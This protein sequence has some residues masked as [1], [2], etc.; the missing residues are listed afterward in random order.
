MDGHY[1]AFSLQEQK[2][3]ETDLVQ[4]EMDT[5]GICLRK[6]PARLMPFAV[7]QEVAWQFTE[8]PF[9]PVTKPFWQTKMN[10]KC[11]DTEKAL[12]KEAAEKAL[13]KASSWCP[14]YQSAGICMLCSFA[15]WLDYLTCVML[16]VFP[17]MRAPTIA[18]DTQ[19]RSTA[20]SLREVRGILLAV[21]H[22]NFLVGSCMDRARSVSGNS[23]DLCR[24]TRDLAGS[25][26]WTD[27]DICHISLP[28]HHGSGNTVI[29]ISPFTSK[30]LK[31]LHLSAFVTVP[32]N[33]P[34]SSGIFCWIPSTTSYASSKS[35]SREKGKGKQQNIRTTVTRRS[36]RWVLV[37]FCFGQ[38]EWAPH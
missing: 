13:K 36:T 38:P 4:L 31:D 5:D 2:H 10:N 3:G 14:Y 1:Q 17:S 30:E 32:R 22:S 33:D 26:S 23:K 16:H 19:H 8:H 29:Q 15:C 27:T 25:F 18:W 20:G 34:D 12:K 35:T 9:L 37:M 24:F 28:L 21:S 6:Q 11:R 7:H